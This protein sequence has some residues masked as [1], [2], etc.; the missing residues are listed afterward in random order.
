MIIQDTELKVYSSLMWTLLTNWENVP[1]GCLLHERHSK[2]AC[3]HPHNINNNTNARSLQQ[4][5]PK[6]KIYINIVS[7]NPHAVNNDANARSLQ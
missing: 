4:S 7:I 3:T 2:K 6:M 1:V 5:S